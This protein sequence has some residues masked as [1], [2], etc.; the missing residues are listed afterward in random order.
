MPFDTIALLIDTYWVFLVAALL[1]GVV[2]G[3]FAALAD[4]QASTDS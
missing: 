2:T 3:W 1:I 4:E